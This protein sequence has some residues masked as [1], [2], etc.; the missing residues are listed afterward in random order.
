MSVRS[1]FDT[2]KQ[3]GRIAAA[4]IVPPTHT[5]TE[6]FLVSSHQD[7]AQ[8]RNDESP[9]KTKRPTIASPN[10]ERP[11]PDADAAA[12]QHTIT[13]SAIEGDVPL[14][15]ETEQRSVHCYACLT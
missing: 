1:P 11:C 7:N 15:V 12:G 2:Q 10:A 14:V 9:P 6:R 3:I 4:T 5:G 13:A 8:K